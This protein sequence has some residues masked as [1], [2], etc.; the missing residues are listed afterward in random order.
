MLEREQNKFLKYA[1]HVLRIECAPHNYLPVLEHLK[2]DSLADRRRAA[3][4]KFIYKLLNGR[5][6][7]PHL[8]SFI[9]IN[10]P[11]LSLVNIPLL[12]C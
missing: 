5:I 2:L 12:I 10:N 3:N 7:S 4:L 8:L 9:P 1:S 11:P 6:D